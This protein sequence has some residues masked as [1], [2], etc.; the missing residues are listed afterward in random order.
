VSLHLNALYRYA[1]DSSVSINCTLL[2]NLLTTT[3]IN[4]TASFRTSTAQ[5]CSTFRGLSLNCPRI[6]DKISN[7]LSSK[8]CVDILYA[9][10]KVRLLKSTHKS[11]PLFVKSFIQQTHDRTFR[12]N[13]KMNA[14][15][16]TSANFTAHHISCNEVF[17]LNPPTAETAF[18]KSVTLLTSRNNCRI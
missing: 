17:S 7:K 4:F 13:S 15:M 16:Y 5:C 1:L 3:F 8:P 18:C 12:P 11:R 9:T 6:A 10:C 2:I 14:R